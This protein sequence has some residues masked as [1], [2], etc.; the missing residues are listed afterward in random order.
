MKIRRKNKKILNDD[1]LKNKV[2]LKSTQFEKGEKSKSNVLI[3]YLLEQNIKILSIKTIFIFFLIIILSIPLIQKIKNNNNY[4][5]MKITLIPNK[6]N[7]TKVIYSTNSTLNKGFLEV[8]TTHKRK[9]T[10]YDYA[11]NIK[12]Y[13]DLFKDITYVPITEQN[14][15]LPQ[16]LISNEEYC[17][18]CEDG[19]LLDKTKYKRNKNP[20]ISVVIPYYNQGNLSIIMTL[21]SIQNQSLKDIEIIIVDDVSTEDNS[22]EIFK[23]MK[24]DNRIIFLKH[25]ERKSTL[26]TRVDG[27]RYASGEYII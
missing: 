14:Y 12:V 1:I 4:E 13:K 8:N 23:E 27:I 26:L 11:S 19:V 25:I 7:N 22:E 21:R 2:N 24:N 16:K 5:E 3:N 20:K 18:L 10:H 6:R 15:I 17:K 9:F